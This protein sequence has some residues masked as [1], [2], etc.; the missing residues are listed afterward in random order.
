[1]YNVLKQQCNRQAYTPYVNLSRSDIHNPLIFLAKIS[2]IDIHYNKGIDRVSI[3]SDIFK[4]KSKSKSKL[5]SK[6]ILYSPKSLKLAKLL[7][8]LIK[9]EN[10]AWYIKPNWDTWSEDIDKIN[11]L[12]NR[13]FEQIE[14]MINWC[15]QDPFWKQNILSPAKL[16]KQFNN[17]II[18]AKGK[19]KKVAIIK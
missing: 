11:R 6:V 17:L 7:Y 14:W 1:M 5:K 4:S 18:K 3:E 9:N 12:D 16:R 13:T 2:Q 8:Q 15:Q 10:P 19:Q